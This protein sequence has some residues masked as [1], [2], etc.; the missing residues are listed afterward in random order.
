MHHG[1][2]LRYLANALNWDEREEEEETKWLRLI[3]EFKYDNY[4]DFLVG[5]RFVESLLDWILQFKTEDRRIAYRFV[6]ERLVFISISEMNHLVRRAYPTFIAPFVLAR[7]AGIVGVPDYLVRSKRRNVEL[8]N[9]ISRRTLY[10]GLSDGARLDVFRRH[11]STTVCNEQIVSNYQIDT[12]KW[13]DLMGELKKDS[14]DSNAV[15]DIV[16]LLDDFTASGTSLLRRKATS[17]SGKLPKTLKMIKK[18]RSNLA[19]DCDFLVHHYVGTET[20]REVLAENAKQW[21]AFSE[22]TTGRFQRTFDLILKKELS[23]TR[24][25]CGEMRR[26]IEDYYDPSIE[27]A[28]HRVGGTND[29]KFGFGECGLPLVIEHNTPNNS[30]PVLWAESAQTSSGGHSMKPLFRRRERHA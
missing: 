19:E 11:N 10:L 9:R 20:A 14:G 12:G 25:N 24:E 29:I 27:T 8:V 1:F 6:R 4:H 5:S 16:V 28:H 7:A 26:L 21:D 2:A 3:S 15:F 23:L 18:H 17:W 22:L 13:D 30:L